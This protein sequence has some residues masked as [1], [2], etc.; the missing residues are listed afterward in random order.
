M[1]PSEAALEARLP[2][3][4]DLD[5]RRHIAP[6]TGDTSARERG[7]TW[8]L[9]RKLCVGGLFARDRS[10]DSARTDCLRVPLS[11]R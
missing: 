4:P 3:D 2:P 7:G 9:P 11:K 6:K 5:P 1:P 10:R 8:V